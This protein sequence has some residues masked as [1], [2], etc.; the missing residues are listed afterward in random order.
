LLV[1]KV[2]DA[3]LEGRAF[4]KEDLGEVE[5]EGP[6]ASSSVADVRSSLVEEDLADEALLGAST[7]AKMGGR[8]EEEAVEAVVEAAV[9]EP[10]VE[11]APKA[12]T[13]AASKAAAKAAVSEPVVEAAP[14]AAVDEAAAEPTVEAAPEANVEDSDQEKVD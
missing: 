3:V 8:V 10:A 1:G 5:Y 7:L 2:A 14:E 11:E 12:A 9:P 4:R 6:S 13:K